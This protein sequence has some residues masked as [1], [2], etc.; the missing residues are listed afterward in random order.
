MPQPPQLTTASPHD[1]RFR[2][3][4]RPHPGGFLPATRCFSPAARKHRSM[5]SRSPASSVAPSAATIKTPW[6]SHQSK[7]PIGRWPARERPE[8]RSTRSNSTRPS[9]RR[10]LTACSC[11]PSLAR[12]GSTPRR[13]HLDQAPAQGP[14]KGGS[15]AS[16][17]THSSAAAGTSA[18]LRSGSGSGS[19]SPSYLNDSVGK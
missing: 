1:R 11:G 19:A 2:L 4:R 5:L 12:M 3:R 6:E 18:S 15:S 7:P 14:G 16:S 8:P 10:V 9:Y 13:R 17:R